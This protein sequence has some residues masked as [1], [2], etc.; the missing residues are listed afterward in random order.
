MAQAGNHD[1]SRPVC[2]LLVARCGIFTTAAATAATT[3]PCCQFLALLGREYGV[4]VLTDLVVDGFDLRLLLFGQ[5]ESAQGHPAAATGASRASASK[6][7]ALT[8]THAQTLALPL[9]G[10][11]A[12]HRP[13]SLLA[14]FHAR[15]LIGRSLLRGLRLH[16]R[17]TDQGECGESNECVCACHGDLH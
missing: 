8:L 2:A 16:R 9:P 11:G 7:L 1:D 14:L 15:S 6:S 3:A 10:A 5:V 12:A 13:L 4:H 17:G